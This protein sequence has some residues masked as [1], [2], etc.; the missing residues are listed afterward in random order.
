MKVLFFPS[1][2][3]S[4]LSDVFHLEHPRSSLRCAQRVF[5]TPLPP[6]TRP[7]KCPL[8]TPFSSPHLPFPLS[9]CDFLFNHFFHK[10]DSGPRRTYALLSSE[11]IVSSLHFVPGPPTRL[12]LQSS[13]YKSHT[14]PDW[15]QMV[16]SRVSLFTHFFIYPLPIPFEYRPSWHCVP[17]SPPPPGEAIL[18]FFYPSLFLDNIFFSN[19][20]PFR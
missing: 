3:P 9:R 11:P 2:F 14:H 7:G 12:A 13:L 16:R 8:C 20:K 6:L 19:L 18:P 5:F 1:G 17:S 15:S 10:K 4:I